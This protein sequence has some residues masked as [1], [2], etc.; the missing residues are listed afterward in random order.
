MRLTEG[1]QKAEREALEKADEIYLKHS[2][3][4]KAEDAL[5]KKFQKAKEQLDQYK[6][7][8][9]KEKKSLQ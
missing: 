1:Q 2:N 7:K 5:N 9:Y 8:F 4:K 6:E 3:L